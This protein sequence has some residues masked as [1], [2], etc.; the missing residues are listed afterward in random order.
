MFLKRPSGNKSVE[1]WR[2]GRGVK[3]EDELSVVCIVHSVTRRKRAGERGKESSF[4]DGR[5][6][7]ITNT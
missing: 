7:G 6:D 3:E 2:K 4:V 5:G 1:E